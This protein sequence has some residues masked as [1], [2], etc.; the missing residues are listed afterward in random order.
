M[1][2]GGRGEGGDEFTNSNHLYS[3][4]LCQYEIDMDYSTN[5]D[6]IGKQVNLLRRFP[7]SGIPKA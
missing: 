4:C 3:Y 5:F 2:G 6:N 1:R 7:T